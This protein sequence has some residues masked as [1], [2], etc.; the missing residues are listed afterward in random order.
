MYFAKNPRQNIASRFIAKKLF[1]FD[2][3]RVICL[4]LQALDIF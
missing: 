3:N 1:K 2:S 4:Y